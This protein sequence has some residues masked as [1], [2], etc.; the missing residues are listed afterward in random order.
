MV[1]TSVVLSRMNVVRTSLLVR[2]SST[3]TVT[4]TGARL[5]YLPPYSPDMNPIEEAFSAIKYFLRRHE[6]LALSPDH[7]RWLI[8]EA[9]GAITREDVEGWFRHSGYM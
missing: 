4:R 5:V 6:Y 9:M 7:R 3:L 2:L 8:R 1:K